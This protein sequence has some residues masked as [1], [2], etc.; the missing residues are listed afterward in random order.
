[1]FKLLEKYRPETL[2]QKKQRLRARAEAKVAKKEDKPTKRPNTLRAGANTVTKLI[3]QKKAQLVVIAHDVDPL[4]VS[5]LNLIFLKYHPCYDAKEFL[6]LTT[7][8]NVN[9][10]TRHLSEQFICMKLSLC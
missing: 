8:E 9:G 6:H 1:M 10:D 7:R 3:E 4:E 2:Q 5:L